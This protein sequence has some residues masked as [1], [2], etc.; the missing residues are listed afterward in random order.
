MLHPARLIWANNLA[1]SS[2]VTLTRDGHSE[3]IDLTEVST[4]FLS[5]VVG[6]LPPGM[7]DRPSEGPWLGV[8]LQVRDAGGTWLPAVVLEPR[9]NEHAGQP[10]QAGPFVCHASIGLFLPAGSSHNGDKTVPMVLPPTARIRWD[11]RNWHH[12]ANRPVSF[13][14]TVISLYGR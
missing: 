14:R 8:T 4:V 5:V 2:G 6:D 10:W 12:G 3:P 11:V 9:Y 1:Q 7:T 13:G